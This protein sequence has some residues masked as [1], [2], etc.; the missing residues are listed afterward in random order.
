M[1]TKLN[2]LSKLVILFLIFASTAFSQSLGMTHLGLGYN[3]YN[4]FAPF[5]SYLTISPDN[6]PT[7]PGQV[8]I[9]NT[10]RLENTT[11]LNT[12]VMY[13]GADRFLHNFG[14]NNIFLGAK[15]G[16]FTMTGHS[17][18]AIGYQSML[19]TTSGA[20][21]T[22]IGFNSML[23]NTSGN[24]NTAVGLQSL[25]FNTSGQYNTAVGENSL[26]SNTT[27]YQNTAVGDDALLL[28][29]TGFYNTAVG[30]LSSY[31]NTI[32]NRN[33]SMGYNSLYTN[34]QGNLN[35]AVGFNSLYSNTTGT[36]NS[37]FGY[38][39]LYSNT[40]GISNTALGD[41]AGYGITTG[42]NNT[43]V[44]QG[45]QVPN[46][47]LSN[48]VRVGNTAVTYAGVQVAWTIT[49]DRRWKSD[50]FNSDLGLNFI[51]KLNPVSYKRKN[52]ESQKTEYGFIAQDVAEVLK[53]S[54]VDNSGMITIDDKGNYEMRYNDLLAP[55]VKAIQ[56]LKAENE[57]LKLSNEKLS[58]EVK[59]FNEI[60]D[61]LVK[62]ELKVNEMNSVKHTSLIGTKVIL[63]TSK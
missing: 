5:P 18:V 45:A 57:E 36:L 37:A 33:V 23:S 53:E 20:Q 62:L 32:G 2:I 13:K 14:T 47:T 40:T 1:K 60:N 19:A 55:M 38:N 3:I 51:S 35:S 9:F 39:S 15:S 58:A 42:S 49:S 26:F 61:K 6:F 12:G 21:N 7:F 11:G 17:N 56:E 8:K 4:N 50:I 30:M 54:N 34:T 10:L 22:A 25:Y 31:H 16:N 52:D 48:Q 28:N 46:G 27:G 59:S 29:T 24:N 41:S 63:T 44:G 43:A